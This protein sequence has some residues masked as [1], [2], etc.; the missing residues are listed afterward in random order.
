MTTKRLATLSLVFLTPA[1]APA[2]LAGDFA[3]DWYTIDG[4]GEM[5]STGGDF[6]L[7]GCM[8]QPDAGAPR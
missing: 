7:G 4:G 2:A 8:G 1:F 5:F 6:V 3:I